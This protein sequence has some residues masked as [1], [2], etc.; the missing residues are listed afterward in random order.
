MKTQK[1][2]KRRKSCEAGSRDWSDVYTSQGFTVKTSPEAG[3]EAWNKF[4]LWASKI[5]I[6]III[7][8]EELGKYVL[9][10]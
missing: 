3:R 4:S 1:R 9:P 7:I 2:Q 5:I 10:F 6:M 8:E